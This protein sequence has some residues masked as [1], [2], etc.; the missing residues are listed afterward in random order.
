MVAARQ[1]KINLHLI[2]HR[3]IASSSLLDTDD[4]TY[5]NNRLK[6]CEREEGKKLRNF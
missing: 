3:R 6:K 2:H 5:I 1:R 4:E